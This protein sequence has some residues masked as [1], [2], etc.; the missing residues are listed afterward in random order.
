M[1]QPLTLAIRWNLRLKSKSVFLKMLRNMRNSLELPL[2]NLINLFRLLPSKLVESLIL[3]LSLKL[4]K[5][6]K[7]NP[8][9]KQLLKT[10]KLQ[11]NLTLIMLLE[12]PKLKTQS[13]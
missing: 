8:N 4:S 9:K 3:F 12:G 1:K 13:R 10:L 5:N 2:R 6:K 7:S 11:L